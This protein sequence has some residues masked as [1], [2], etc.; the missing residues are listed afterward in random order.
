[1]VRFRHNVLLESGIGSVVSSPKPCQGPRIPFVRGR[2]DDETVLGRFALG[3]GVLVP[4]G[5]IGTLPESSVI[6]PM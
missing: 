5:V 4:V 6:S 3:G 1:M 2:G